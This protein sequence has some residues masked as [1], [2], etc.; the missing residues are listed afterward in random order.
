VEDLLSQRQLSIDN[1]R[2]VQADFKD[3]YRD[4]ISMYDV[5][6][7]REGAKVAVQFNSR[8]EDNVSRLRFD[9]PGFHFEK[10]TT[11]NAVVRADAYGKNN[12]VPGSSIIGFNIGGTGNLNGP[13]SVEAFPEN[14]TGTATLNL[15]ATCP[16]LYPQLF[17][18]AMN[19]DRVNPQKMKFSLMVGYEYPAMFEYSLKIKYNMYKLYELT[20]DRG[21]KGGFF[22][23]KSWD[24]KAENEYFKDGFD[25]EWLSQS[26][27]LALTPDQKAAIEADLRRQI[28]SR[29]ANFL[30]L[31]NPPHLGTAPEPGKAGA[32]VLSDSISQNC[33]VNLLCKGASMG[34]RLIYDIFSSTSI[35]ESYKQ[36]ID[37]DVTELYSTKQVLMQPML[38]TYQ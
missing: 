25:V 13:V 12:I 9:N 33:G 27:Q 17:G 31:T 38:T 32:L 20:E 10:I 6:A 11:Q 29:I 4:F 24:N 2:K 7:Q 26:S 30:V 19:D 5:H 35:T 15:L 22:G 34:L 18:L 1:I 37:V 14:F 23:G 3:L 28:L 36:K 21:S 16:I 8:W